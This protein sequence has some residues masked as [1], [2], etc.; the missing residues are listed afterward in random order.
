MKKLL[1]LFPLALLT[2]GLTGCAISLSDGL[3]LVVSAADTAVTTLQATGSIPAPTATLIENYLSEVVNFTSFTTT[4]LASSDSA[5]EKTAKIS[6]EAAMVIE[7]QLPA[8]TPTVIV[9]VVNAVVQDVATFLENVKT[10]SASLQTVNANAFFAT[11]KYS[12]KLSK[13]DVKKLQ[14]H[15]ASVQAKLPKK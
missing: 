15:I 7:P 8:G 2:V 9:T 10:T 6:A 14:K 3:D 4:E 5:A 12:A 11:G 13:S 1:L